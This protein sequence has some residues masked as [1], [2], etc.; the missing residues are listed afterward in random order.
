LA[1]RRAF[2]LLLE[3]GELV[4]RVVHLAELVLNGLHL[5]IQVVLALALLHLLLDAA[6][7]AFLDLQHVDL[8]LDQHDH[9]LEP[10]AHVDHLEDTS[11]CRRQL[12]RHVRRDG[13]GR[14]DRASMP[15]SEVK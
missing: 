15:D 4:G 5:L 10:F 9:V 14:G 11:A 6:A 8:A 7:D 12:D 2:D 3:L 13:V 1:C